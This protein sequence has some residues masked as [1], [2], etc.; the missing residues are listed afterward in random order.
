MEEMRLSVT[1]AHL[2]LMNRTP[3]GRL[4][5]AY[6]KNLIIDGVCRK[7]DANIV[8]ILKCYDPIQK[9][10]VFGGITATIS[11]KDIAEIFGL[12]N[13]GEEINLNSRKRKSAFTGFYERCLADVK[14]ISKKVLEERILRVVKLH[15]SV[16]E[17]DFVRLFWFCERTHLI[18]LI[19]GR[20]NMPFKVVKW[21]LSELYAKMEIMKIHELEEVVQVG[22]GSPKT[23]ETEKKIIQ[24]RSHGGRINVEPHKVSDEEF[25]PMFDILPSE[26]MENN[27]GE[28]SNSKVDLN[29]LERKLQEM[30]LLVEDYCS[31]I[32]KLT[33]KNENLKEELKCKENYI[34][35]D[36]SPKQNLMIL[37][38]KSKQRKPLLMPDYKY[39]ACVNKKMVVHMDKNCVGSRAIQMHEYGNTKKMAPVKTIDVR[40]L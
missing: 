17:G 16:H 6:H 8:S 20:E 35:K 39:D 21:N 15:G 7:C 26:F 32:M 9:A 25:L 13:E 2:E 5:K 11:A 34:V 4:F 10:F 19:S 22:G 12:P 37:L 30:S 33:I 40:R 23:P 28:P 27:L 24:L 1:N 14:D 29:D 3:F 38:V 31:E 18:N 36:K